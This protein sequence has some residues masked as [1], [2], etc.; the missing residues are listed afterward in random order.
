MDLAAT[1]IYDSLRVTPLLTSQ[2]T[3][4]EEFAQVDAQLMENPC[5]ATAQ[6]ALNFMQKRRT[7]LFNVFGACGWAYAVSPQ[8]PPL[9]W[10]TVL[11]RVE[12]AL[13]GVIQQ[14]D[15]MGAPCKMKVGG[16]SAWDVALDVWSKFNIAC[17]S[18]CCAR[19]PNGNLGAKYVIRQTPNKPPFFGRTICMPTLTP[20][21]RTERSYNTQGECE[22]A[23]S[24]LPPQVGA[25]PVLNQVFCNNFGCFQQSQWGR[26]PA[27]NIECAGGGPGCCGPTLQVGSI[28]STQPHY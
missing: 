10:G 21:R 20:A 6:A 16:N 15:Y 11:Q 8:Q 17:Q 24:Q 13:L 9:H 7:A 26:V 14:R 25:V 5:C 1:D 22:L 18:G 23:L 4:C 27:Y 2:K 19:M 3:L 28:A 12:Q